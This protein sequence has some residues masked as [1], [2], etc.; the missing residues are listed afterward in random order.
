[1]GDPSG[2][3]PRGVLLGLAGATNLYLVG[4]L[5]APALICGAAL[6]RSWTRQRLIGSALLVGAALL[7]IAPLILAYL[8]RTSDPASAYAGGSSRDLLTFLAVP[9]GRPLDSALLPVAS[10]GLF[11][12][13]LPLSLGLLSWRS[14]RVWTLF[15]VLAPC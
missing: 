3:W 7:L 2:G 11:P 1:M 12:G 13:F 14:A 15:G 6:G 9:A 4:Y 5:T 8:T 10:G